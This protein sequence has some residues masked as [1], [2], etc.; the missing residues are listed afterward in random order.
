MARTQP[1]SPGQAL[2]DAAAAAITAQAP[3][4]AQDL[5]AA[6]L[7]AV[8]A[9]ST[10]ANPLLLPELTQHLR[11]HVMALSGLLQR[12]QPADPETDPAPDQPSALAFVHQHAQ[13]CAAQHFP[14]EAL[15][16]GYQCITPWFRAWATQA[17][18][19]ALAG[20]SA[21]THRWQ[22]L[23]GAVQAHA[24]AACAAAA[25]T[26]VQQ[27]R[28]QAEAEGD[29]RTE[30]LGL[31]LAGVD[32]A[33]S[34]AARQLK[35]AGY[36]EQRQRFCVLLVQAT[37]PLE[38]DSPAR[39]QRIVDAVSSALAPL[40]VRLLLGLRDN[41]VTA[42]VSDQR[43]LSGWTAPQ[44]ALCQRLQAPLLSLGPA[45]LAGL[46]TDQPSTAFI[47][48]GHQEALVAL[49]LAHVGQRLV[50]FSQLPLR[51]LLIHRAADHV[52]PALPAWL[53]PLREADAKAQGA[54][55]ATLRALADADIN[56]QR[57]ART[58]GLHPNTVYARLQRVT[59]LTGLD[60]QRYHDLGQLLL[61]VDCARP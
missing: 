17:P 21:A 8:P 37:D 32:E 7:A 58:L 25:A 20:R 13:R 6:V 11:Q 9:Y 28:Q 15:L 47:P 4:L 55:L 24:D 26:Y 50:A 41:L 2:A 5:A 43:R 23:A 48:R 29:R 33:D 19:Q 12:P 44:P 35:R 59:E 51:R 22:A 39:A 56:V 3:A 40:G 60:A 36:L 27:T 57:A 53:G 42:V 52:Q 1:L 31:L 45:V 16:Q 49:D 30:L 18:Q 61:A 38:M 46:S 10:S 14:L 34:H 54:L